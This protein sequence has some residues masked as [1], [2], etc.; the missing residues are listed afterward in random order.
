MLYIIW[1]LGIA[2]NVPNSFQNG[3]A[4]A[5]SHLMVCALKDFKVWR[6]RNHF[7]AA[8]WVYGALK[9]HSCVKGWFRSCEI[10]CEMGLWLRNWEFLRFGISLP[11]R[12]C[13]IRLLCYEMAL[14]FQ[15]GASQLQ[16]FSQ[17]GAWGCEMI[18]QQSSDFTAKWRLRS[19]AAI[20][21]RS[22]DFAVNLL[23][24]QNG[25]AAKHRFCRGFF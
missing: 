11:F 17:R 2:R 14:V 10:P 23:G 16:K 20:L 3:G 5:T 19:K 25:F 12:S 1:A 13:E 21:Q 22:G 4:D 7:A 18:S 24:L 15:E 6:F 8:K 9:W